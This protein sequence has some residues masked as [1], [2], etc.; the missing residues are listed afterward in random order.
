MIEQSRDRWRDLL[1]LDDDDRGADEVMTAMAISTLRGAGVMATPT[2]GELGV[3]ALLVATGEF[4]DSERDSGEG[5][6][7]L[8]WGPHL[9]SCEVVRV[10]GVDH[11]SIMDRDRGVPQWGKRLSAYLT[12]P[13]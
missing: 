1:G 11:Y 12:R 9:R 13:R 7:D 10:D 3:D 5:T 4:L 8:L 2:A 6:G